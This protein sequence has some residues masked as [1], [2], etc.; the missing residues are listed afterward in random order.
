M[1]ISSKG[2][3]LL[4]LFNPKYLY[5]C[6]RKQF[7]TIM[8]LMELPINLQSVLIFRFVDCTLNY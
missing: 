1:Y 6:K 7:R 8:R 3:L 5:N 4:Q 2:L